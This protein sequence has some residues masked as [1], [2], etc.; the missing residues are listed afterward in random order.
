MK[1]PISDREVWQQSKIPPEELDLLMADNGQ[2][3]AN[4][5]HI[6]RFFREYPLP[7]DSSLL[8]H[9]CGTCQMFDYLNPADIG[10]VNI[11]FAD[12]GPGMLEIARR[13][14]AQYKELSFQLITDD[15]ENSSL[16]GRY[17]AILLSML[18]L[19][20]DWRKCLR[21]IIKLKPGRI[22][23]IE[24]EQKEGTQITGSKNRPLPPTIQQYAEAVSIE[25]VPRQDLIEFLKESGYRLECINETPVPDDKVMSGFIF[26]R[27]IPDADS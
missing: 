4:A 19:H 25:L 14:L 18:L 12:I 3:E 22:F 17:D 10:K 13:R 27:Q 26:I 15:V 8:I 20:V 21:N 23:I 16:E 1:Q 9:G 24:Q 5:H 6:E 2:A 11:T 7:V